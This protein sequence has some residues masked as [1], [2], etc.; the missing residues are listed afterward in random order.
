MRSSYLAFTFLFLTLTPACKS[1]KTNPAAGPVSPPVGTANGTSSTPAP[2]AATTPPVASA[3]LTC[4]TVP[5]CQQKLPDFGPATGFKTV[6]SKIKSVATDTAA[7]RGRD[8]LVVEGQDPSIVAR[9][10]LGG[11]ADIPVTGEAVDIYMSKGCTEGWTKVGTVTTSDGKTKRSMEGID[12][13]GG[14][15]MSSLSSLGVTGLSVGRHHFVLVLKPNNDTVELYIEVLPKK[16]AVVV[17]DIDGTLTSSENAAASEVIRVHPAARPGAAELMK[18]FYTKGYDIFYLTARPVG[19]LPATR[20]WLNVRGFPPGVIH[21]TNLALG[22]TG[23]A[24]ANFKVN[25]LAQLRKST[26]IVP[27][28][29]FG[30]KPSDVDAF[31]TAGVLAANSY[32]YQL[33]GD[34]TGAKVI[35]DYTAFTPTIQ[36]IPSYCP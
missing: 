27:T 20:D 10:A 22:A 16:N 8:M 30:N 23:T 13:N 2:D 33:T 21:T 36:S 18:D 3:P 31:K 28:Y 34:T 14:Y 17:S 12:D 29:A 32:F 7:H 9:F 24:A 11:V 1:A 26:G 25:E 35:N 4:R 15:V 5:E 19:L 6:S